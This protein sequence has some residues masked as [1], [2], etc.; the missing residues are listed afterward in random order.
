MLIDHIV[1]VFTPANSKFSLSSGRSVSAWEDIL[2]Y[3]AFKKHQI[4]QT[5]SENVKY[6]RVK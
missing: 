3:T 2:V 5:Y 1:F 6:S 4:A